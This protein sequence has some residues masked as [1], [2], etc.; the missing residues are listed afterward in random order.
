MKR[1]NKIIIVLI[2]SFFYFISLSQS[3][4]IIYNNNTSTIDG[5][6]FF[7]K[8]VYAVNP[9]NMAG[10]ASHGFN[11]VQ[12]YQQPTLPDDQM[13]RFLMGCTFYLVWIKIRLRMM[14]E[15]VIYRL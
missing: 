14:W 1:N 9:E 12:S 2:L 6:P 5:V 8:G 10:A 7:P 13:Q 4:T 15:G 11:V 3:T